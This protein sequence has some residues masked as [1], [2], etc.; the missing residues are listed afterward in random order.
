MGRFQKMCQQGAIDVVET[1]L[2]TE[3][4]VKYV[5]HRSGNTAGF[6]LLLD[7]EGGSQS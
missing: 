7:N 2:D 3:T 6:T 5:F 4:V 1:W